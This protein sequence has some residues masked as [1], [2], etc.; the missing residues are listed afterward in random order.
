MEIKRNDSTMNRPE[1][2][3]VLDA[4]FV[5]MDIDDFEKQLKDEE[6]WEKNDRN[7]ITIFKSDTLTSVVTCLHKDAEIKDN[8][9]DGYFQVH[10]I[11]GKVKI[12]TEAGDNDMKENQVIVFH[13]GV[14]HTI[15][16]SKKSTLLLQTF[17]QK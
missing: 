11:E 12:T 10:V 14:R 4:P 3:R 2:D 5:V 16:A 1:G 13:P 8:S 7:G 9:V 6:A 15:Q 17:T